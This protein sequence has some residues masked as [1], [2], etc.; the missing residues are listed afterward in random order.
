MNLLIKKTLIIEKYTYLYG[1]SLKATRKLDDENVYMFV[2]K[3]E[4]DIKNLVIF[5]DG[6]KTYIDGKPAMT[7]INNS[8]IVNM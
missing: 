4:D 1:Y 8:K 7:F 5:E 2:F 3:K 6:S